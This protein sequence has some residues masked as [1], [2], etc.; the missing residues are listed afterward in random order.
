MRIQAWKTT[1][2]V[3]GLQTQVA[4]DRLE[5]ALRALPYVSRV[6]TDPTRST[7]TVTHRP[8]QTAADLV[9]AAI[10]EL[11]FVSVAKG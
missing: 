8:D 6:V 9:K 7:V 10:L 5:V 11:G 2:W 4:A 3:A 1:Y